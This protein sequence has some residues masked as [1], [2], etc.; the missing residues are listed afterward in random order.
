MKI[1]KLTT[2]S[3]DVYICGQDSGMRQSLKITIGNVGT[4]QG[5]ENAIVVAFVRNEIK[6][7]NFIGYAGCFG[8]GFYP[9][10]VERYWNFD[11]SIGK[12]GR[13]RPVFTPEI[14]K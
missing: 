1:F 3:G 14:Y 2:K 9:K 7:G 6:S 8:V 10:P 13:K 12:C 11:V 4:K 5:K